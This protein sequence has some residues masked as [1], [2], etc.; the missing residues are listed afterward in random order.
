[1][2]FATFTGT[3]DV[4]IAQQL[5]RSAQ[6]GDAPEIIPVIVVIEPEMLGTEAGR[7]QAGMGGFGLFRQ[8]L[9]SNPPGALEH[10]R[11]PAFVQPP[12]G[13]LLVAAQD[14]Q[15]LAIG[16]PLSLLGAEV[17]QGGLALGKLIERPGRPL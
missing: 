10:G 6:S 7:Q 1:G 17:A 4:A 13:E 15:H 9:A 14:P 12:P 5:R 3:V 8:A 16:I 2:T 11:I